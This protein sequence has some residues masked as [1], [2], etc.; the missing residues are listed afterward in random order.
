MFRFFESLAD[1]YCA[2]APEDRPPQALAAFV[3]RYVRPF[4]GLFVLAA[5]TSILSAAIELALIWAMGWVVDILSGDPAQVWDAHGPTL[6]ALAVFVLVLRPVF[7]AMDV[8][9]L[10]NGILPNIQSKKIRLYMSRH[11]L[12][13]DQ[14]YNGLKFGSCSCY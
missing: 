4:Q 5:L 13:L 11:I 10:N 12:L 6:I 1:P 3:M 2:Y 9:L 8:T 14:F 7:Q